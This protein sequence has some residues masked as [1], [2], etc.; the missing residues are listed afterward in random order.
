MAKQNKINKKRAKRRARHHKGTRH[1]YRQGGR[2]ALQGGGAGAQNFNPFT[3]EETQRRIDEYNAQQGINTPGYVPKELYP[4]IDVPVPGALNQNT[5]GYNPM[6]SVQDWQGSQDQTNQVVTE[7]TDTT[8]TD[9][10]TDTTTTDTGI[11]K[12]QYQV[13][14]PTTGEVTLFNTQEEAETFAT[15]LIDTRSAAEKIADLPP[16]SYTS[17]PFRSS[18]TAQK[19]TESAAGAGARDKAI[20]SAPMKAGLTLTPDGTDYVRYPEGHEKAG[21]PIPAVKDVKA[22]KIAGT[23]EDGKP[24]YKLDA[25]TVDN[26]LRNEDGTV[27]TYTAGH[28]LAGQPISA[29]DETVTEGTA[30]DAVTGP[31]KTDVTAGSYTGATGT[32]AIIN[33]ATGQLSPDAVASVQ[34][35]SLTLAAQGV[36]I[37][38]A[39]ATSRLTQRVIGTLDPAAKATA[40]KIAGTDLPR[41][42]RA[43]KQ[44]RKAG[45]TEEQINTFSNDPELL[46]DKLM[47]YTET[48][49]GMIAGLPDEALVNTQLDSLLTGMENGEIPNFA[50]P[51][52]AAVNQLMAQR[53]LDISTVG[54]DALFNAII[55]SAIPLAQ[56]NA[57]SI[58]E[59]VLSQRSIEA[60]AEQINAQMAQQTAL[61]NADKTFNLNMA[62]FNADQQTALSNSK[63][64]QTVTFTDSSNAQQAV[65]QN[66]AVTAQLDLA[67]LSTSERVA[68]NNAKSFLSMDMANLSNDQQASVLNGQME[69]QAML[70]NQAA[71]NA[72]RQF[73]A[74]SIQQRDQFI[75][76]LSTQVDLS[77]AARQDAMTQFNANSKNAAE[78][79]RVGIEADLAKANAAMVNDIAKFNTQVEF[80]RTKWNQMNA[81]A[82]EMSNVDWRRKQ[83]LADTAAQNQVN[84]QNA[85]NAY[86]LEKTSMAMLWQEMRDKADYEF[87]A[88]E[89][90]ATRKTQLLATALGNE[91]AGSA[92]NWSTSIGNLISTVDGAIYGKTAAQPTTT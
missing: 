50:K 14:N 24:I 85:M 1:D 17:D 30:K 79:R 60:Q 53:G 21:E 6:L 59:S 63:F 75:T 15:T 77:N 88:S 92:E 12:Q 74:T 51:A 39:E 89:N 4:K 44:L 86:D 55:Q 26:Y 11:P 52:V 28:P 36:D 72:A 40:A 41:V 71:D 2:V 35:A 46:E 70:S 76:Q 9:T 3:D 31:V 37:S 54:R 29:F 23:D 90:E 33:P 78:A 5:P 56:S 49:R 20:I 45:L 7:P 48:Q 82:V 87:K 38:E 18:A 64:L 84:M 19:V 47:D 16:G 66:A 25:A 62:Q 68:V 67:N 27:A 13:T 91:G 83:N 73:N 61:S 22:K 80:D 42:L 32:A 81:Q 43:K 10:G 8:T 57:Q 58:K 65:I 69:Q 34:A